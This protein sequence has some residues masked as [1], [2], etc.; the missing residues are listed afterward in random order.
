MIQV[1][2]KHFAQAPKDPRDAAH[3][4]HRRLTDEMGYS[5]NTAYRGL[6]DKSST[7][8]EDYITDSHLNGQEAGDFLGDATPTLTLPMCASRPRKRTNLPQR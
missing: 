8:L 3:V 6:N 7:Y 5:V 4:P 1:S 2:R